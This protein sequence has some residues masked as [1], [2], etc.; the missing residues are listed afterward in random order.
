MNK[1]NYKSILLVKKQ[2]AL[3][4]E[5]EINGDTVKILTT[6]KLPDSLID[7]MKSLNNIFIEAL[8]LQDVYNISKRIYCNGIVFKKDTLLLKGYYYHSKTHEI[9]ELNTPE[10]PY[11]YTEEQKGI[12]R[13][14]GAFDINSKGDIFK[15]WSFHTQDLIE[16]LIDETEVLLT[17]KIK[18]ISLFKTEEF[19]EE[20]AQELSSSNSNV[21]DDYFH[22]KGVF[23]KENLK[24]ASSKFVKNMESIVNNEKTG[25][26]GITFSSKSGSVTIGEQVN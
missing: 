12:I 26:S 3:Q 4:I 21:L 24:K 17:S 10:L 5:K 15:C 14:V 11:K 25:I 9:I 22:D 20:M 7:S 23:D 13:N 6:K 8:D 16:N 1:Q 2:A 19:Y 18:Q